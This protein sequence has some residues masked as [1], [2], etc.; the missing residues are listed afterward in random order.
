MQIYRLKRNEKLN[1][2]QKEYLKPI[3]K[4]DW[5]VIGDKK[6]NKTKDINPQITELIKLLSES[7][8]RSHLEYLQDN[9]PEDL[10]LQEIKNRQITFKIS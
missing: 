10:A 8:V 5:K 9:T 1:S 3:K 7:N 2:H 4:N 6:L